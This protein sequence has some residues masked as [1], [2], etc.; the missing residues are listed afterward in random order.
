MP[1]NPIPFNATART[2]VAARVRRLKG[3]AT[4]TAKL[5]MRRAISPAT[6]TARMQAMVFN[7][8]FRCDAA[9][10]LN[11]EGSELLAEGPM[12]PQ[13]VI[14]GIF[15]QD[16]SPVRLIPAWRCTTAAP[17]PTAKPSRGGQL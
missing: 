7:D 11:G 6:S 1:A 2:W 14:I 9:H 13:L 10:V 4:S 15:P 17:V 3:A 5:A 12:G 8:R 16:R